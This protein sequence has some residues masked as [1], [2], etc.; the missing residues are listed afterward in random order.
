VRQFPAQVFDKVNENFYRIT[1]YELC[2]RYLSHAFTFAIET[3]YPS[4]RSDW[5]MLGKF[6][7]KYKHQKFL[8][9]FKHY[10]NKEG[11]KLKILRFKNAQ[12]EDIDQVKGYEQDILKQFP[13]FKIRS[14]VIYIVG[15]KG[16]RCFEVLGAGGNDE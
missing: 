9:E 1:F 14:Y 12:K 7:T 3:N 16:F 13:Y 11:N 5:E 2:T 4:G 8:V 15:N 10:S 6:H